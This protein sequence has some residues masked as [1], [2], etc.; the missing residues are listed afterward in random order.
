MIKSLS[1][2][3]LRDRTHGFS[4]T[5]EG[6]SFTYNPFLS[7]AF[8][9]ESAILTIVAALGLGCLAFPLLP[10]LLPLFISN[11][12]FCSLEGKNKQ[13]L[14]CELSLLSTG[15]SQRSAQIRES[16]PLCLFPC[17]MSTDLSS[18][19]GDRSLMTSRQFS[20]S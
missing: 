20:V 9:S 6:L 3:M 1:A 12:P 11:F 10:V 15:K 5:S 13:K 19:G 14:V 18:E 17:L 16:G 2:Q 7:T 4:A 8:P